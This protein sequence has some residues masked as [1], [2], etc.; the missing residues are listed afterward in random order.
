MN[1]NKNNYEAFFLDY[2]EGNLSPQQVADLL[3]FIEQHPELKEEFE[4]FE[5]VTLDDLSAVSFGDKTGLKK[6]IT[7]TN[8]EE[9]LIRSIEGTL[10]PADMVLLENFIKQHPQ[11][12][13]ELELFQKTKLTADSSVTFENKES[14][15][16]IT[17]TTDDLLIASVEGL[18]SKGEIV[19]LNG[20]L[21]VDAEMQHDLHLY[22]QTKLTADLNV[23]YENK[24]ELKRKDR[25]I[26]PFYYY[27]AAAASILL[28]LGM[29]FLYN[30]NKTKEQEFADSK[31][32]TTTFPKENN[33][34]STSVVK[35]NEAVNSTVFSPVQTAAVIKHKNTNGGNTSKDSTSGVP[36]INN[37]Q[38]VFPIAENKENKKPELIPDNDNKQPLI[39]NNILQPPANNELPVIASVKGNIN[40]SPATAEFLSLR[41]FAAQKIKEK[42]LDEETVA[43][44]K[45]SGRSKRLTGWD[46]AQIVT[47]G[48]SKVTGRDVEVK[49]TYDDEGA[50]TAYALGKG[51]EVSKGR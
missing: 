29:F 23:I 40:E 25:K 4:S 16:R 35:N 32:N 6:E 5:N 10:S 36:V 17:A 38:P 9:Y 22:K 27:V 3:L 45:K 13:T 30:N 46:M 37:E 26:I 2:H 31:N 21:T 51:I 1:I 18:L 34:N 20:Q 44:Q 28:I 14:L 49:P 42:T 33:N 8:A 15:K 50:I 11:Y 48:I 47:R 39:A 41:E 19:L 24:E 43:V 7:I 12:I